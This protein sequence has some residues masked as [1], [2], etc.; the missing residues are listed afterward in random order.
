MALTSD[1]ERMGAAREALEREA[2]DKF[3]AQQ[4]AAPAEGAGDA[5]MAEGYDPQPGITPFPEGRGRQGPLYDSKLGH[6]S[7]EELMQGRDRLLGLM[8]APEPQEADDQIEAYERLLI[9][10]NSE[11]QQR[12]EQP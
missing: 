10:I 3:A 8:E 2:S 12:G 9:R 4:M 1:V 11:L 7:T 5:A 6:K